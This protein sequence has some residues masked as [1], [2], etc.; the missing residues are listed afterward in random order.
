MAG[1]SKKTSS[2]PAKNKTSVRYN[3][4]AKEDKKQERDPKKVSEATANGKNKESKLQVKSP[5]A[6]LIPEY[7]IYV[8]N[9]PPH[10][11]ENDLWRLF[12]PFG[13]IKNVALVRDPQTKQHK[14]FGFVTMK[15][16]N[17]ATHAIE[18]LNGHVLHGRP[19]KISFKNE[20]KS[21]DDKFGERGAY[22]LYIF[23]LSGK[24]VEESLWK[25][26]ASF[27]AVKSVTIMRDSNTNISKGYAFVTMKNLKDAQ[28]AIE[29]LNN[30]KLDGRNLSVSFKGQRMDT[31]E[32]PNIISTTNY[33]RSESIPL[34]VNNL[35]PDVKDDSI[36]QL[37]SQFGTLND[38]NIVRNLSTLQCK[39]YGFVMMKNLDEATLAVDSLDGF[40]FEDK[41]L[42]VS[43]KSQK[44]IKGEPI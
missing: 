1:K 29:T 2:A 41:T 31:D 30:F 14:G 32:K 37:F 25:L 26:F 3:P 4:I 8:F 17:E 43:F 36:W 23:N 22:H 34:Y 7:D 9:L 33:D 21:E 16:Q 6:N 15:N 27:G 39:G 44:K 24:T 19:L 11:I 42:Q 28:N 13:A 18:I 38:I 35:S 10:A 40:V 5:L 12:G 20:K